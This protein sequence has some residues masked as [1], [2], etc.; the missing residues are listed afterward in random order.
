V[1]E[2]DRD[3]ASCHHR[4]NQQGERAKPFGLSNISP[5]F[6][7]DSVA[8]EQCLAEK[9]WFLVRKTSEE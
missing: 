7:T 6:G 4:L 2:F 9:G 3:L 5:S 8:V 1:N